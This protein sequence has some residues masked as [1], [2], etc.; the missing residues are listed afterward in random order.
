MSEELQQAIGRFMSALDQEFK[1]KDEEIN[2][3]RSQIGDL[4]DR[5]YQ[6]AQILMGGSI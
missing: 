1:R 2:H 5:L 6:A 4:N 3:L